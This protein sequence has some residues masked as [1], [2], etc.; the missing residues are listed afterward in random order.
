[1]AAEALLFRDLA[2]VFA[3]ALLGGIV[4]HAARQP[5]TLGYVAGGILIGPF[6]PGPTVS[7]LHAFELLAEIGVILR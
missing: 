7:D 5:L 6:T 2:Y 3:A 1:M 4:A